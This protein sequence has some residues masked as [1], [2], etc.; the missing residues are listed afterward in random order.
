[1]PKNNAGG[2]GWSVNAGNRSGMGG[3]GIIGAALG[4]Y[5]EA[6]RLQSRLAEFDY[7]ENARTEHH[8]KRRAADSVV[9]KNKIA[10]N[11]ESINR[12]I[13]KHAKDRSTGSSR[14]NFNYNAST[15]AVS[16]SEPSD[17]AERMEGIAKTR[18]EEQRLRNE[19]RKAKE[20]P[21]ANGNKKTRS[22]T[23]TK[24]AANAADAWAAQPVESRTE[25]NITPPA[26]NAAPKVRKPRAPRAPKNPGQSGGMQ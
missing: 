15:G 10:T 21:A 8:I 13:T 25:S 5:R 6:N 22:N 26:G 4:A 16:W 1:M 17:Y 20:T 2:L 3:G 19:G 12:I 23:K 11:E 9:H 14:P 7:K 24:K 18:L